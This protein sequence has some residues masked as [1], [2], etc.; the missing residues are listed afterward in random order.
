[1]AADDVSRLVA[2]LSEIRLS[3]DSAATTTPAPTGSTS[4]TVGR[5]SEATAVA[6]APDPAELP[7]DQTGD[8]TGAANRSLLP[9]VPVLGVA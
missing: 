5:A 6:G 7:L 2:A 3:L 9:S 8:I 4:E 1:M